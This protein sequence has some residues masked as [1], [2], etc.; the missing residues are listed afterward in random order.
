MRIYQKKEIF[1][2]ISSLQRLNKVLK[3]RTSVLSENDLMQIAQ[4][5]VPGRP[6]SLGGAC[7]D[8]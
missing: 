5:V 3:E 8:S 2:I 7:L 6:G 4:M 1:H